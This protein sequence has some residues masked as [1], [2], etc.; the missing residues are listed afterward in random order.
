MGEK[1]NV[2]LLYGGRSTEH[3]ISCRSA[4][5][6]VKHLPRERYR[7]RAVAIDKQGRLVP[8]DSE[9]L[10]REQPDVLPVDPKGI[11]DEQ[12]RSWLTPGAVKD[13]NIVVF[14]L[15]HGT[16]GE[17]GCVQGL[18]ELCDLPYVGCDPMGAAVAMDKVI[19]KE[20]VRAVGVPVVPS[21]W[22][23]KDEWVKEPDR[24]VSR[25]FEALRLPLFCKPAR[26]G[27]SV[28]I[29]K[30]ENRDQLRQALDEAFKFDDK[31]L[32]EN[33]L[34]VREIEF[35]ALGG[36]DPQITLGGESVAKK[37]FYDYE[38]K[39]HD[40]QASEVLVPAPLAES[41]H[42]EGRRMAKQVFQS[43]NLYGL[44]R[45]DLFLTEEGRFLLNEVNTM[46]GFTSISQYPML[47]RH[48]GLE[49]PALLERL[50]A[51]AFDRQSMRAGLSRQR[52]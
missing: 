11:N 15:L 37:G 51:T 7:L 17:D 21:V 8:Q 27:S 42:E 50:F 10:M 5:F 19:T 46:P 47:W 41:L 40:P 38:A 16:Y 29:S 24:W 30:V 2:I 31:V 18:L 44:A 12:V 4:G 9:A 32:V 13:E 20:L 23:R 48:H 3:E 39:Y 52:E 14:P 6:V 33:G 45:I 26:L 36:Y 25:I 22:L 49:G 28:G 35:A 1:I 43:L 34:K